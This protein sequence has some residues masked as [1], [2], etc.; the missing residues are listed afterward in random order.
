MTFL[1][2]S[3]TS[4]G[5][6]SRAETPIDCDGI[7]GRRK[8]VPE[9]TRIQIDGNVGEFACERGAEERNKLVSNRR[10]A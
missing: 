3:P 8:E 6:S 9:G 7:V 10:V 2:G 5:T 4:F 1:L